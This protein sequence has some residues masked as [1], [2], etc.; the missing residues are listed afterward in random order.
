MFSHSHAYLF[1]LSVIILTT[2]VE[3]RSYYPEK[4]RCYQS[5]KDSGSPNRLGSFAHPNVSI[6]EMSSVVM[7]REKR[8]N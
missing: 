2:T 6:K 5:L 3:V 1:I 7:D 4:P 8:F